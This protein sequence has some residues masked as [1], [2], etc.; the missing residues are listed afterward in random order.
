M[1]LRCKINSDTMEFDQIGVRKM[2]MKSLDRSTCL[3]V[4]TIHPE[5]L[6]EM[7]NISERAY[8]IA[9]GAGISYVPASFAEDGTSISMAAFNKILS[10]D[11]RALILE[12]EAGISLGE[13]Y[14][15]LVEYELCLPVQPG[16]PE[17]SLGGCIAFNCHGKNQVKEGYF[18]DH[19]EEISL[20]HPDKGHLQLSRSKN[21]DVFDLTCGGMGLTGVIISAKIRVKKINSTKINVEIIKMNSLE[22][23]FL[24]LKDQQNDFDLLYSWHNWS[25]VFGMQGKGF[26]VAGKFGG[27]SFE[28]IKKPRIKKRLKN[29]N[30]CLPIINNFTMPILNLLF[31]FWN[32]YLN[33][34]YSE[35]IWDFNFPI[36]K[37]SV[38]YRAFGGKGFLEQQVIIPFEKASA[39]SDELQ[40]IV[41][42]TKACIA[43]SSVKIFRGEKH[44]LNFS[45]EGVVLSLDVKTNS[46][47]LAFFEK[48]DLLNMRLGCIPNLSKDSRISSKYVQA[49]YNTE[50]VKFRNC[51]DSYDRLKRFR[52][53]NSK[54]LGL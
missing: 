15:F 32:I 54:R 24:F 27:N 9:Q 26:V 20:W 25:S 37:K 11:E 35:N 1:V 17:I 40:N 41:K 12:V 42:N 50:F 31:E 6:D 39:Y 36:E 10:F 46:Q 8:C 5:S 34:S 16:H 33:N 29:Q 2:Q 53:E 30:F 51:L 38:Y 44:F 45:G 3:D 13:I 23:T 43:L 18:C 22:E 47:G 49:T 14:Q 7:E 48:L 4:D 52:S 21:A 28:N 19:V